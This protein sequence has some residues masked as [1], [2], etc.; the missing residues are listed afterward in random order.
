MMDASRKALPQ[1]GY[2]AVFAI[3]LVAV[4]VMIIIGTLLTSPADGGAEPRLAIVGTPA[5]LTMAEIA[6]VNRIAMLRTP[7]PQLALQLAARL[8]G[9]AWQVTNA[10]L[11][12][13]L[14]HLGRHDE[15][16]ALLSRLDSH[17][18][19]Q[20]LT[21]LLR[22]LVD[23]G[24]GSEAVALLAHLDE[25]LP[26]EP[27]LRSALLAA[28]GKSQ[29]A[30]DVLE[31]LISSGRLSELQWLN[32]AQLQRELG[33]R[34]G[35]R[36]SLEHFWTLKQSADAQDTL[37][38]DRYAHELASLGDIQ[39]LL[40][41]AASLHPG[42]DNP[43]ITPLVEA[44]LFTQAIEQ[45]ERLDSLWRNTPYEQLLDAMLQREYLQQARELIIAVDDNLHG[46]LL[47]RLL[48]RHFDHGNTNRV[49]QDIEQLARYEALRIDLRLSL[50]RLYRQTHPEVAARLLDQAE[51]GVTALPD[52]DERD[53]LHL[54]VIESR[55]ENQLDRP[56]RQRNSY[57][58]RQA[59]EEMQRITDRQPL[60]NQL[61][62]LKQQALLLQRLGRSDDAHALLNDVQQRLQNVTPDETLDEY[63]LALLQEGLAIA[64]LRLGH[65]EQALALR[66]GLHVDL[67]AASEWLNVLV[68]Q[69]HLEQAVEHLSY[70]N[71]FDA[72]KTL[73]TLLT[74]LHDAED[75]VAITLN[76]RLLDRLASDDFWPLAT[77]A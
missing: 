21:T 43:Y 17:H 59:L 33:D 39:R 22:E 70:R 68:E 35:A 55:L 74:K 65:L 77:A 27:L 26:E 7:A 19:Q 4:T 37:S 45:I 42:H 54:F 50:F 36:R 23:A 8:E 28:Q 73:D 46:Q 10:P 72:Q 44:G 20:A 31:G 48:R 41:S 71:L 62:N 64:Y 15:A 58:L 25:E 34:E 60:Y 29:E 30:R 75:E 52:G 14:W 16:R 76:H 57:E 38:L 24:K 67:D 5:Q 11:Y 40:E 69:E 51:Q 63:D 53:Q 32:L 9:D 18:R 47:L 1:G 13:T 56:E 12:A 61:L 66:A 3:L 6:Q 49:E 2:M